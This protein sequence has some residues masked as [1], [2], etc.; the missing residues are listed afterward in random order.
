MNSPKYYLGALDIWVEQVKDN[1]YLRAPDLN[2]NISMPIEQL[3]SQKMS[4]IVPAFMRHDGELTFICT[5]DLL[6]LFR[7]AQEEPELLAKIIAVTEAHK[8][9]KGV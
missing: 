9:L 4:A 5:E 3:R 1:V 6:D 2:V 7:Q 8:A